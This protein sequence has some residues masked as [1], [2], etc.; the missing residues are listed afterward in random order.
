MPIIDPEGP[1]VQV[2]KEQ[3]LEDA[4]ME[5]AYEPPPFSFR[6]V[7]EAL[8]K[9]DTTARKLF[10]LK[11]GSSEEQSAAKVADAKKP[12]W[13]RDDHKWHWQ[14]ELPCHDK[15]WYLPAGL[16]RQEALRRNHNDSIAGYFGF[17]RTLE[18]VR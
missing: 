11:R 4:E 1:T 5:C 7:V 8:Q 3:V 15:K 2:S 14:G 17:E 9:H 18:L 12:E 10:F 16:A 13:L 6:N